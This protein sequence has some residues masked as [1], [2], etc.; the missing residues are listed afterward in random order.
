MP[1]VGFLTYTDTY[2]NS[3]TNMIPSQIPIVFVIH[4]ET[5]LKKA[6]AISADNYIFFKDIKGASTYNKL[7]DEEHEFCSLLSRRLILNEKNQ[8]FDQALLFISTMI[9]HEEAIS[10]KTIIALYSF[11]NIRKKLMNT[12]RLDISLPEL[13]KIMMSVDIT[14]AFAKKC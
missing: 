1:H 5:N 2:H 14:A 11:Y 12:G 4:D 6:N 8:D 3:Q 9:D 7:T 10:H 13:S